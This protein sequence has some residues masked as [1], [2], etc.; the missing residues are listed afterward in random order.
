MRLMRRLA[1]ACKSFLFVGTFAERLI[2]LARKAGGQTTA[3][4]G[5][6]EESFGMQ[7]PPNAAEL[8]YEDAGPLPWD[9]K[10]LHAV[11][12]SDVGV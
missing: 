6:T 11:L 7:A 5:E 12:M 2:Q 9:S 4:G 1:C 8:I 10:F 3:N